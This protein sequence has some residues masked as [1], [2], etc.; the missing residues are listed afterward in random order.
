[1]V[2]HYIDIRLRPDPE[3]TPPQ[4]LSALYAR[5]H[6]VLVQLGSQDIGVSFP[7]HDDRKPSLGTHLRLHG[8]VASLGA[9]MSTAWLRGMHDYFGV[10][11]ITGAPEVVRHRIVSRVQAKSG[12]E[13]L[14]RRAIRRHGIDAD[15][16]KARIPDSAAER[17]RLPFVL[18]GSRSTGQPSFP[19]FIRHGELLP[20][21]RSGDFNSYGLSQQ[22]TVPWF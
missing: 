6:R 19:L 12:V 10:S 11:E 17:L 1:M 21:P 18:L 14:R 5:L 20:E 13:R 9:L 8:A 16:A 4:L 7:A 22:A 15:A 3:V 2:S